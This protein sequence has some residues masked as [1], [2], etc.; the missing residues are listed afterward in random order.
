M[1]TTSKSCSFPSKASFTTKKK[2]SSLY[3]PTTNTNINKPII[4]K[5]IGEKKKQQ[6]HPTNPPLNP[7]LAYSK[8]PQL[9][10]LPLRAQQSNPPTAHRRRAAPHC[11]APGRRLLERGW[12]RKGNK[13]NKNGTFCLCNID[14]CIYIYICVCIDVLE[15]MSIERVCVGGYV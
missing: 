7:H 13:P 11:A 14:M 5:K 6:H 15:K 2:C 12:K 1:T 4:S 9:R 10:P 8:E 3:S